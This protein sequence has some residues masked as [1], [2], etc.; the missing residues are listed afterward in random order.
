M[1][2]DPVRVTEQLDHAV[3]TAKKRVKEMQKA[4]DDCEYQLK[5]LKRYRRAMKHPMAS[6][7]VRY[8]SEIVRDIVQLHP[9]DH[10]V[11]NYDWMPEKLKGTR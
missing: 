4:L 9:L 7:D 8:I 6:D 10:P 11:R 5:C 3:I 1:I 2:T